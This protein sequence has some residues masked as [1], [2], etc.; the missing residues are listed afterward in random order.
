M[1]AHFSELRSNDGFDGSVSPPWLMVP[2]GFFK[3]VQLVDGAGLTLVVTAPATAWVL[4]PASGSGLRVRTISINGL[5]TGTAF[6]EARSG[7]TV[8]A[9]LEVSVKSSKVIRTAFNFV[10]DNATPHHHFTRRSYSEVDGML[11]TMN[12]IYYPQT[13]ILFNKHVV[14][15]VRVPGNL[16]RTVIDPSLLSSPPAGGNEWA[17]VTALGDATADFNVFFVWSLE[18]ARKSGDEDAVTELGGR[19]CLFED[20][21]GR[22]V[23]ETL[24]HEAG[25]F[26]GVNDVNGHQRWLMHRYTD[27]RGRKI[28]RAH[29]DIMNP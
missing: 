7:S 12:A 11:K 23:G 10:S 28:P 14:R 6:I 21:A 24:A 5:A 9:R 16:G 4:E 20:R 19:N 17:A 2:S 27:I 8:R 29:A 3:Q 22:D 25:H 18:K 15:D 1:A 26:L 13:N